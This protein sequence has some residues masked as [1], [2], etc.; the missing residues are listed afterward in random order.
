[1]P[2]PDKMLVL[3]LDETLIYSR[4]HTLAGAPDFDVGPFHVYK[5][6]HL[7][8]FLATCLEWFQVGVWTSASPDYAA[9]VVRALFPEPDRLAFVWASDR[10]TVVY[11]EELGGF[12]AR[13]SLKKLLRRGYARESV[14]V[15]DD[16]PEKWRQ[17][18]GNLVEVHPF[19]GA[20]D[21]E[22]LTRLLPYLYFLR[23]QPD[24]RAVDKRNWRSLSARPGG[25]P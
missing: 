9:E 21:D 3:D 6:P 10:C 16:S 20:E 17:S 14:I 25:F 12:C 2:T 1:M 24:V 4:R 15:V 5:R 23:D 19:L 13:K 7:D 18:Y 11:D 8:Y 22:E